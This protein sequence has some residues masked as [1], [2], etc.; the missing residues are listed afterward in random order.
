MRLKNIGLLTLLI[1]LFIL[2]GCKNP[3]GV[4]L[5]IDPDIILNSKVIDTS[6]VYTKLIAEDSII[7]NFTERSVLSYIKDNDFGE[8]TTNIILAPTLPASNT[9][10]GTNPILDSAVLVLNYSSARALYGDSAR[11]KVN[12]H[13][14]TETVYKDSPKTYYAHK[15]WSYNNSIIASKE[16]YPA[17]KDSLNI[18]LYGYQDSVVKVVPQLRIPLNNQF[19]TDNILAL[20]SATLSTSQKFTDSFK[21]LRL[22]ID[23]A[24]A[25]ANGGSISFDTYN[26]G[27]T[28][29]EI[30]YRYTNSEGKAD[31]A[32]ISLPI[33][34]SS[35][36]TA[37]TEVKWDRTGTAVETEL[38]STTQNNSKLY[39]KGLGGT[40]IK[41]NF[42]YLDSLKKL[43]S[44][45]AIN[46]A[47]LIF[48]AEEP[49]QSVLTPI[50]QLRIY[51]WDL[52]HQ[53]KP[54]PDEDS[55]DPRY[56]GQGFIGG[57][58]NS[59]KKTYVINVTGYIQ[60]L[61]KKKTTNFNTFVTP[62]SHFLNS[63][64]PQENLSAV[65]RSIF[66][67]GGSTSADKVKLKI[68]YSDL[69]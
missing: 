28:K 39:L 38:N 18:K 27:A 29:L 37:V 55:S 13:Q 1:S 68:Y 14:L 21:G 15:S 47:E 26:S 43:G 34:G 64:N 56:M 16:F 63:G 31:T 46:R 54:L 24:S 4:G 67:G 57:T 9:S 10:F 62:L 3:T 19:I 33:N 35:Y 17:Y 25:P 60:D 32:N 45:I 53:P 44:N 59:T 65:G 36:G 61:F 11:Y 69:K 58:Y 51:R 7:A 50:H 66:E 8:T 22:S 48:T 6:S 23:Q 42:P 52:A 20:D 30:Y 41:L 12:V 40:K 5:D 2:K 49:Q